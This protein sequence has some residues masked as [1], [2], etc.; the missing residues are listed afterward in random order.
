MVGRG[1]AQA[2][3]ILVPRADVVGGGRSGVVVH[4]RR[5]QAADGEEGTDVSGVEVASVGPGRLEGGAGVAVVVVDPVHVLRVIVVVAGLPVGQ[6]VGVQSE[7]RRPQVVDEE[8]DGGFLRIAEVR[9]VEVDAEAVDGLEGPTRVDVDAGGRGGSL[10]ES[11][12]GEPQQHQDGGSRAAGEHGR[13]S[14]RKGCRESPDHT[15]RAT[16]GVRV[17][18]C[19]RSPRTSP[20]PRPGVDPLQPAHD[21]VPLAMSWKWSMKRTLTATPP[22]APTTGTPWAMTFSTTT[23]L[24][25]GAAGGAVTRGGGDGERAPGRGGRGGEGLSQGRTRRLGARGRR[26]GRRG[27]TRRARPGPDPG[28]ETARGALLRG[29][30]GAPSGRTTVVFRNTKPYRLS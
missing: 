24:P 4:P 15:A 22:R 8:I 13:P 2:L 19:G 14:P 11:R 16:R 26:E 27:G 5:G 9:T 21:E 18:S 29:V 6:P 12:S 25:P 1:V 23:A 28:P 20:S 7:Q 10:G 17:S 3:G 30:P